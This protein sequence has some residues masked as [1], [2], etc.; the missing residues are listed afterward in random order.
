MF[1]TKTDAGRE[2]IRAR[3]LK[4]S[5]T[6]RTLLLILEPSK[7]TEE[8]MQMVRGATAD[9]L[10]G[11]VALGLVTSRPGL[12][13]PPVLEVEIELP[14]AATAAGTVSVPDVAVPVQ[15]PV[16][17]PAVEA[18]PPPPGQGLP[19]LVQRYTQLATRH[20]GL[21][22]SYRMV[23]EIERC[24]SVAELQALAPRL[25]AAVERNVGAEKAQRL[26]A[27]LDADLSSGP[28]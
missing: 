25:M 11:L 28:R 6:A 12:D 9:D 18:L 17:Q 2:E 13:E 4:L 5:R 1:H 23:L 19:N 14:V 21:L 16:P 8:W 20:L 15:A 22:E 7:P 3:Q 26:R 10:Q 24:A 27:E